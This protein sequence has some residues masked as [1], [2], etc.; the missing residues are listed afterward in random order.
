MTGRGCG[1]AIVLMM[2][3][4]TVWASDRSVRPERGGYTKRAT[5]SP[6]AQRFGLDL[7]VL[8]KPHLWLCGGNSGGT[9][10]GHGRTVIPMASAPTGMTGK[11]DCVE[12]KLWLLGRLQ[13]SPPVIGGRVWSAPSLPPSH[14]WSRGRI[15]ESDA[16][17]LFPMG[18]WQRESRSKGKS[19]LIPKSMPSTAYHGS[20]KGPVLC[21]KNQ[22]RPPPY[23]T[24]LAL[25]TCRSVRHL[26]DKKSKCW[27]VKIK[28]NT[29]PVVLPT[30]KV[31]KWRG[32]YLYKVI[33][34]WTESQW[35]SDSLVN[36]WLN[37]Y[38]I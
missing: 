11:Y 30:I 35:Q 12:P 27:I 21:E 19:P 14:I 24:F 25:S 6:C 23:L 1:R 37:T 38:K 9:G 28:F 31:I 17:I 13:R 33:H 36:K 10:G 5:F 4:E 3:P 8:V 2:G 20:I 18:K 7:P 22:F 34:S 16:T 32:V 26:C 29:Q 15:W